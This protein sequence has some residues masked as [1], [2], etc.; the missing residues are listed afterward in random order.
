MTNSGYQTSSLDDLREHHAACL[1]N[2]SRGERLESLRRPHEHRARARRSRSLERVLGAGLRATTSSHFC[3]S[4]DWGSEL[5][6]HFLISEDAAVALSDGLFLGRVPVSPTIVKHMGWCAGDQLRRHCTCRNRFY[7]CVPKRCPACPLCEPDRA[8]RDMR[9]EGALPPIG[10]EIEPGPNLR[11]ILRAR[12]RQVSELPVRVSR[13]RQALRRM[14]ARCL[15]LGLD[16]S[17]REAYFLPGTFDLKPLGSRPRGLESEGHDVDPVSEQDRWSSAG[18]CYFG[19]RL[20]AG[21]YDSGKGHSRP[22]HQ[23]RGL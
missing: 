2:R 10:L 23:R 22:R 11:A 12:F 3:D 19:T 20:V 9:R 16:Y 17:A 7:R 8:E 15:L 5:P 14:E 4:G 18:R 13:H 1:P 6:W 21:K